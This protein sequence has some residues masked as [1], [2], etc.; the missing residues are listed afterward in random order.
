MITDAFLKEIPKT[1]VH[2]HLDGSLRLTTLIELAQK[3]NVALPFYDEENLR[4]AV[5]PD[6]YEDLPSYLRG[7]RYTCA[8]MQ[9]AED[10]TR[11]SYE[12]AQDC[13]TEGVRYI[14]VRFA[15]QLHMTELSFDEVLRAVNDGLS[16][17]QEEFLQS[18]SVVIHQE[19]PFYYG[20]ICCALRMFD[21]NASGWYGSFFKNF[22]GDNPKEIYA[23]ASY[24]LARNA[25]RCRDELQ[26]PIVGLDLAGSEHGYRA[27]DHTKA[28]LYGHHNLMR[29]TV[30][31]GEAYHAASIF[32]ALTDL[33]AD[34]I[35]H[36]LNLFDLKMLKEDYPEEYNLPPD[37]FLEHLINYIAERRL[38][39]E[40]CV[41]S[42]LQT[43]PDKTIETHPI[44]DMFRRKLSV[45]ICTDNRLIS[46]TSIC[47]EM[48]L[49]VD[50][51]PDLFNVKQ[52]RRCCTYG[53]KRSFLSLPYLEKRS[54]V[55]E[56]IDFFNKIATKHGL[57]EYL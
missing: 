2:L 5:F 7:F 40:V 37:K 43:R 24:E 52:I 17:A 55:R 44:W 33:H 57:E 45:T 26:I 53:F 31:A 15:P 35:G 19:P 8:V 4:N 30:H 13:I 23:F 41:S 36:A 46:N 42:N 18:D 50:T 47:K 27:K 32:E 11:I 34:R 39:I 38:T 56:C 16:R 6:H 10:L 28:F 20:I 25:V 12:L 54:Y 51:D 29:S 9:K 14:E 49:L 48:R 22:L 21:E 1:D 3:N